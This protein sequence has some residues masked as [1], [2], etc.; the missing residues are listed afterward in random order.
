MKK[1]TQLQAR[2]QQLPQAEKAIQHIFRR[3]ESTHPRCSP[4]KKLD[5][6]LEC[7][8]EIMAEKKIVQSR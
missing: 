5:L 2:Y 6:I 1:A 3:V 7:L 4:R 8:I